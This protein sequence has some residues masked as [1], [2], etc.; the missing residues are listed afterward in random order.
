MFRADSGLFFSLAYFLGGGSSNES[1]SN[2]NKPTSSEEQEA[3]KIAMSCIEECHIEQILQET[4]FLL[5]ES[6]NELLKALIYSFQ[7][8]PDN[9]KL[10][11]ETAVF[12]LELLVKIVIQNRDRVTSFWT[13]VRNQFYTILV[14]ATEKTF[15]VERTCIGILRIASR[16]LRREELVS[17]VNL[18]RT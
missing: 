17:E 2:T 6:L 9:Q 8:P 14:N 7:S 16:L 4:K 3:L 18:D 15:F 11:N 13:T 12:A 10:D 1:S 5:I